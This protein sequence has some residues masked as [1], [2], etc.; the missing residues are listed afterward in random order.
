[1][2]K[3]LLFAFLALGI[4]NS[5]AQLTCAAPTVL[6]TNGQYTTPTITGTYKVACFAT[7]AS[8]KAIWYSFTA[9]SNG[10]I[11][12]STNLPTNVGPTNSVDT[13]ISVATGLCTGTLTCVQGNDDVS[14]TNYLSELLNVPVVAGTTY[15]IEFDSR[16]S[17]K[18]ADF[19]FDFVA[20]SCA[21]PTVF[22]LPEYENTTSADLYWNQTTVI[23]TSYEVDWSTDYDAAAGTGTS[24]IVPAGA[25]TYSTANIAGLPASS[26]FRYFVRADCGPTE[27][28][29]SGPY[30]GYLPVTL[31]Y[32]NGFED[33]TK[34]FTDGFINFS[35]FNSGA[36]ST[37]PDYADGGAGYSVYTANSTTAVSNLRA[38][39][40]GVSLQAGEEATV[41]FK[42]RL[43]SATTASEMNFDLTVGDSQSAAGQTTIVET[44]IN[45]SDAEYTTHT[46]TYVAPEAGIYY[47]GIHNN[48]ASGGTQTFLFLD[49]ID[50]TSNLSTNEVLAN[51]FSVYP[52]PATN[53][54]NISNTTD[55]LLNAAAIVDLNGR[56]VKNQKLANVTEAQINVSDLAKGVYMMNISTDKGSFTKKLVIN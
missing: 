16:W 10:E 50:I 48:S 40:R 32:T 29:W 34:N 22:Y 1:M 3:L 44:F 5:F 20:V 41:T 28:S 31:P 6:T 27:S 30:Y 17:P 45:S 54:V 7:F 2:K 47:F 21:R 55:V 53:L 42:T 35:L 24:V 52:N 46:S 13:R 19:T 51:L 18:P 8:P 56:T 37:P 25:L 38:Y 4:S 12:I 15:L 39:F 36:T 33:E 11:S 26:N 9:P 23:P 43:Y 14:D 49:S